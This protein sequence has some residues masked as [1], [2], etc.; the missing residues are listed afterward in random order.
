MR[1][2]IDKL[3][4]D[5]NKFL[6]EHAG[7]K[8]YMFSSNECLMVANKVS[9]Q[10]RRRSIAERHEGHACQ[11]PAISRNARKGLPTVTFYFALY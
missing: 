6:E 7:F 1:E 10:W 9:G 4:A 3:M 8:G 5:F 2:A 11:S